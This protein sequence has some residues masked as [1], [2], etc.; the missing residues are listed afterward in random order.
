MSTNFE[1]KSLKP[2]NYLNY[3]FNTSTISIILTF[4]TVYFICYLIFRVYMKSEDYQLKINRGLDV[5]FF[6]LLFL[7]G[8]AFFFFISQSNSDILGGIKTNIST[9]FENTYTIF[10]SIVF[11][12]VFNVILYL[13][14]IPVSGE[15]SPLFA[16]FFIG[17]AF[18]VLVIASISWFF[19]KFFKIS[20]FNNSLWDKLTSSNPLDQSGNVKSSSLSFKGN[21]ISKGNVNLGYDVYNKKNEVFNIS[22]NLYTYD[23]A[24]AICT[25]YGAR[26]ATYNEVEESYNKGGE[27]CNYGWSE[28][29]M[30]LFPTQKLTWFK[31]QKNPK[32]K[33]DCGRPG[34]NGGFMA[35]PYIR[36]GV[37]CYGKKPNPT[38]KDKKKMQGTNK[39]V[40][41]PKTPEEIALDKKVAFWKENAD[42]LLNLNSFNYNKWS[43]Y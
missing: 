14:R 11:I 2:D 22:N 32:H 27:W 3:M 38:E 29:Q 20:L 40:N 8:L 4:L 39:E 30:A 10:H 5:A 41:I 13:F 31:L 15:D 28:D 26:L 43:A 23:D 24:R 36:F 7:Q 35:N 16:P 21:T 19:N 42:K 33:N 1:P 34:V 37:N 6:I 12:I 9:V 25:A 17:S 18:I